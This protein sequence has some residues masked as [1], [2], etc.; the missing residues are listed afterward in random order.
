[1]KRR[2]FSLLVGLGLSF[3][4]Q[5]NAQSKDE[6][7]DMHARL[8]TVVRLSVDADTACSANAYY[9]A[10]EARVVA[11]DPSWSSRILDARLSR[12]A[13]LIE[14][15]VYTA[16]KGD[17]VAPR[18]V[19]AKGCDEALRGLVL[20]SVLALG[21]TE[22]DTPPVENRPAE[23][24]EPEPPV[25]VTP[26]RSEL[27]TAARVELASPIG[28]GPARVARAVWHPTVSLGGEVGSLGMFAFLGGGVERAHKSMPL[29]FR[30]GGT[31]GVGDTNP[32]D[33][34]TH[35]RTTW[36]AARFEACPWQLHLA[37][38][39]AIRPCAAVDVGAV[40]SALVSTP[41]V[42]RSVVWVAGHA[43]VWFVWAAL[44]WLHLQ[45]GASVGAGTARPEWV[46]GE[47]FHAVVQAPIVSLGLR[48]EIHFP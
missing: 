39:T 3:G 44:R 20:L 12:R 21:A 10:L 13:N 11:L 25:P 17:G 36:K 9:E 26:M 45:T 38:K 15:C 19:V 8:R 40:E 16:S 2:L 42:L 6:P 31:V 34:A 48:F 7:L 35:S 27:S 18:L 41:E 29:A 30:V 14:V 46:R 32:N 33:P 47:G 22:R 4:F 37:T 23:L 5:A 28:N 43:Q 1:M 24:A